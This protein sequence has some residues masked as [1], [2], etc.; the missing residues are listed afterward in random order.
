M[1]YGV[2]QIDPAKILLGIP[3]YGYDWTLP[4]VQGESR[5]RSISNVEAQVLARQVGAEIQWDP[6]AMS[7]FFFYEDEDGREHEVWFEDESSIRAKLELVEE[8][9]LAGV[10]YWNLMRY[11]PGNWRVLNEMFEVEKVPL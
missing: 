5:A 1:D 6:V 3:N 8:Y 4:F 11:F 9:G 7:P 2:T 10:S